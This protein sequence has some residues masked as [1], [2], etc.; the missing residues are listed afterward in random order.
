MLIRRVLTIWFKSSMSKDRG[1]VSHFVDWT[2]ADGILSMPQET[3]RFPGFRHALRSGIIRRCQKFLCV[4]H[5]SCRSLH[6]VE[7]SLT[8][9]L[10]LAHSWL[11]GWHA[12]FCSN[13][14]QVLVRH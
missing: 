7:F 10:D 1:G 8:M 13:F 14:T 12:I 3:L 4:V 6:L 2:F 11:T 5:A 9:A